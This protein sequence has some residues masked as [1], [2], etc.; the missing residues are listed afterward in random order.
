MLDPGLRMED[1]MND[2]ITLPAEILACEDLDDPEREDRRPARRDARVE[3][4][5]VE[6]V[7]RL[8]GEPALR[9]D[10]PEQDEAVQEVQVALLDAGL[11]LGAH[12]ASLSSSAG[13]WSWNQKKPRG[14]SVSR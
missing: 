4:P 1:T 5:R 12:A 13:S 2:V 8:A 9:R 6:H 10:R 3:H 11:E 7:A 14:P